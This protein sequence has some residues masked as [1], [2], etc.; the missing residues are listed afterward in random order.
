M[1]GIA[2]DPNFNSNHYIYVYYTARPGTSCGSTTNRV[3]RFVENNGV[4][5]GSTDIFT[6]PQTAGNHN[7]GNIHFGP[8]GKLYISIGDNANA[9]NAQDVTV[10]NGKIHRING[11]GSIPGDNP[12][13]TQ[14][15]A[16]GSLYAYGVR[17]TFDFDFD[18]LTAMNPYPRIFAA[19]NGPS[20]DDEVN[21]IEANYNYGWRDPYPCDDTNPSPVYNT[22]APL[23][24]LP[25]GQCCDAPVGITVYEGN[26]PEWHNQLFMSANNN[27]RLRHYY[28][29]A[30]RTIV[31]Q[32]NIV[33]GISIQGDIETGPDGAFWYFE[34]SPYAGS[35]DLKKLVWNGGPTPTSTVA[36]TYTT[37]P[38]STVPPTATNTRTSTTVP[39]VTRTSTNTAT[40][41]PTQTA[42]GFTATPVPTN[43]STATDTAT[44]TDTMTALPTD[45]STATGTAT[46]T[47][48]NAPT[49]TSTEVPPSP[50]AVPSPTSCAL[51]F[52]DVPVGST[53][54]DYIHCLACQGYIGGYA[55]G[56]PGEPCNSNSDPYFRPGNNISRGQ[57]AKI[58]SN[59]GQYDGVI[60]PEDQ[61]YTDVAPDSTFYVFIQRLTNY[62]IISGYPCGGVGEPCDSQSRPYFRPGASTTRGQIAK[63]VSNAAGFNDTI[64]SGTQT[65]EDV[66]ASN[67]FYVFIERL[68]LNRPG[69]MQG[70]TCGSPGEPCG[71]GNKPYFRPGATATRGQLS[72]IVSNVFSPGCVI[73]VTVKISGFSFHPAEITVLTGTTVRFINRDLDYHTATSD[74]DG[75]TFDTG[76]IY[77]NQAA[78]LVMDTPGTYNYHCIPHPYMQGI[79]HVVNSLTNNR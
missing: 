32:T 78:D 71:T 36:P 41:A 6:S 75:A 37:P 58:V 31:T 56:G 38:T 40:T 15:G 77:Q 64:Q 67:T 24:Y 62:D 42:G 16:L 65:F 3:A 46:D 54:Y 63:I 59:A 9:A 55:C 44:S 39:T 20:C 66:E 68:L 23:W 7:G 61:S 51:E 79:I 5:S 30:T 21:R 47:P 60:V 29:D 49:E 33:Q 22:I 74:D 18:P 72:K 73:P 8:D 70:Y 13:F 26:I 28:L 57:L 50:T 10:K 34:D 76:R 43:T 25:S 2:I 12:V 19:E 27:G 52:V 14:T 53:F 48:T 1:L 69:A 45:T 11:D 17:N 35:V 4:G